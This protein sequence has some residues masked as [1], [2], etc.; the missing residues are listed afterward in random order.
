MI[1]SDY[2]RIARRRWWLASLV[3]VV[4]AAGAY[5]LTTRMTPMYSAEAT[6]LVNQAQV[7]GNQTYQDILSSQQLTKTYAEL[8]VSA[9]NL[10]QAVRELSPQGISLGTLEGAIASRAVRDTQLIRITAEDPS[11]QR[12]ALMANTVARMFPTYIEEAQLAG[13]PTSSAKPLNTVFVAESARTPASPIRPSMKV[14][15]AL[16]IILG[17]LLATALV[18]VLEYR[19]DGVDD[20]EQIQALGAAFLGGVLRASRPSGEDKRGWVPSV[21]KDTDNR[22]FMESYRA[23]QANLAFALG[24]TDGKTLLVTSSNPGE[25]KS[26]TA[27]NLAGALAT[28]GKRVLLVDADMRKPDAHR[29]FSLSNTSGLS[30]AYADMAS[31]PTLVK[32]VSETLCVLTAGPNPPNPAQMLGS[33][34]TSAIVSALVRPFDIVIIDS[35]PILGLADASLLA[36][37]VDG[38]VLV[39]RQGR[40]RRKHL[41]E[42][43]DIVKA[44][45]KP[46]VGVILN[47]DRRAAK[48]SYYLYGYREQAPQSPGPWPLRLGRKLVPHR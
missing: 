1:F 26:T 24:A 20:R 30:T 23:V 46:L 4:A 22:G 37:Y 3:V 10:E 6:I 39:A 41:Q 31:L 12:A 11:A 21:F 14:N 19:D 48:S 13:S 36:S 44:S 28:S 38:V 47:A 9:D 34:K 7:P 25:G 32:Q 16:G 40:T 15:V 45:Q 17:L 2:L 5:G 29:Y 27:A 33:K 8:A 35:P 18:A 43:I 42:S